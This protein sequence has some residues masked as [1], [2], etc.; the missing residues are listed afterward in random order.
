MKVDNFLLHKGR[1]KKVSVS[2]LV[3][4]I[5]VRED[6][7]AKNPVASMPGIFQYTLDEAA[8]KAAE[9]EK[10]GIPAVILFG[11]PSKKDNLGSNA[12]TENGIV[13]QAVRAIKKKTKDLIVIT[14]CCLCEYTLDGECGVLCE[15]TI[16]NDTT[17][18][19]L[20][21]IAV[22]QANA[23]ADIIAPSGMITNMVSTIRTAL[24][25]AGYT[26]TKIMSYSVKY[27][28]NFYG[29]FREAGGSNFKG[30]VR[31]TQIDPM[32]AEISIKKVLTD[33]N[34]GADITMVKP[35]LSYLDIISKV[36]AVTDIALAAYNVSGE[37]SMI[38]FAAA[39]NAVD[40]IK[41]VN[42]ILLSMKRA[43]ADIII[44]YFAESFAKSRIS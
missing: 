21:K 35:A 23:G 39:N 1:H 41:I 26:N 12:Y 22:S 40:E 34:E 18:E 38:K 16:D 8:L 31:S 2:D 44:T 37:Y 10:L 6:I 9:L 42:E 20:G 15:N 3:M 43:G 7:T 25:K 14:D 11:I 29:P 27:A 4:P 17:R 5:F 28:S 19:L 36:R 24:N 33:I 30:K 13:Q 32:N